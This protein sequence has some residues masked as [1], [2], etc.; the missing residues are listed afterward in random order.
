MDVGLLVGDD[1]TGALHDITLVV[2]TTSVILCFNK[3]RLTQVTWKMAVK[4]ERERE[5]VLSLMATG[6]VVC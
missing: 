2:T 3:N 5:R 6:F 4:T 1:L